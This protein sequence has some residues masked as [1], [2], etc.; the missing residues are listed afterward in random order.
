MIYSTE[1]LRQTIQLAEGNWFPIQ[2]DLLK[3][4]QLD[5]LKNI[6]IF[7]LFT[8]ITEELDIK[9][10]VRFEKFKNHIEKNDY[11][12]TIKLTIENNILSNDGSDQVLKNS[13]ETKNLQDVNHKQNFEVKFTSKNEEKSKL[14]C[15]LYAFLNYEKFI[16][17]L[18]FIFKEKYSNFHV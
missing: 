15:I 10:K 6:S 12:F 14:A 5:S 4:P 13:N 9:N 17:I 1:S 2:N 3:S 16:K 8:L 18:K 11:D 7:C